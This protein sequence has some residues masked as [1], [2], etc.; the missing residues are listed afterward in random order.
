MI[1]AFVCITVT[2]VLSVAAFGQSTETPATFEVADVHLSPRSTNLVMRTSVRTG[3]YELHNASM[4]DLIRTAYNVDADKVLGGPTWLEYDR[5]DVLAKIPPKAP[6]QDAL[7]LML[8]ALLEDRF[9]LVV[10]RDT[11]PVIGQVLTVGK[12]K[13]KIKE[14]GGT[15]ETGCKQQQQPAPTPV[16]GVPN[17]PMVGYSCHNITMEAFAAELKRM[18]PAVVRNAVV[19]LTGLKGSWDFDIKFTQPAIIVLI[20]GAETITVPDA[21]DKQ[22]GLKLEEQKIPTPVIVVDKVNEKPADNPPDLAAK[23]PP[24]PPAEFEV[25][26]IKP[27]APITPATI[28]SAGQVGFFP[29]G[30]V[31]LPRFPLMLAVQWGWNLVSNDDIVGAPK[32]LTSTN[33]DIIAKAPAEEAPVTGNAP[34]QDLGPMLKALLIDRFKMKAHFEDRPVNAYTLVAAKPKLKKAD[35]AGRTGCKTANA[36]AASASS[37]PFG[38]INLPGRVVTCQNIT[39]AQFADQLR[40]IASNYVH[41]PVLDGT[42]LEGAWD[43]SFT[44]SLINPN[45]LAGVRGAP[46]PG[47]GPAAPAA[48]DPVGGGASLFDAVEKQLGLKLE[49]QKR[50]YPVL[51]IDHMEEKPTEN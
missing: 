7:R 4:V 26:D 6:P 17:I 37:T 39:M 23:F 40:V 36:P 11:Q 41:Y 30:R 51:V 48:L 20:A 18:A 45:Q 49:M 43:F 35:P 27:S 13:P 50:S 1:R 42:S 16:P 47:A 21:I 31:N 9:K 8:Q 46:P 38:G 34:L 2:A 24:L 32:W 33:F 19:D 22:L 12:G 14:S 25:A 44:Y 28:A 29:G 5:F 3:R 15:G 10:H